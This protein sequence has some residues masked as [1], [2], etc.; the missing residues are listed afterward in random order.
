MSPRSHDEAK[1][2][3][4]VAQNAGTSAATIYAALATQRGDTDFNK[5]DYDDIRDHIFSGSLSLGTE[6]T[7]GAAFGTPE[8]TA[9]EVANGQVNNDGGALGDLVLK[10]GKYRGKT[11]DEVHDLGDEGVGWLEWAAEKT[12]NDFMKSRIQSYLASV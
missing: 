1:D 8:P 7:V 4:I 3:R 10:Y 11:L 9:T 5:A 6:A 2:I 12:N